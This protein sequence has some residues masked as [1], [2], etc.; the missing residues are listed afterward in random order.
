[1]SE[2]GLAVALAEM[3]FSGKAG[4]RVDLSAVPTVDG[5]PVAEHLF[6]ETPGRIV[7][8]IADKHVK[9][10][11]DAGFTIIGETTE[12]AHVTITNGEQHLVH[13]P[14]SELKSLWQNGLTPYY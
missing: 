10:V 8:E 7:F 3:G 11:E 12:D 5:T 9:I 13:L 2:G 14:V 1:M 4:V 6:G